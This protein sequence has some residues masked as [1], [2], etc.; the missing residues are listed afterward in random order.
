[1]CRQSAGKEWIRRRVDIPQL[2]QVPETGLNGR[3]TILKEGQVTLNRE[4]IFFL[5]NIVLPL[6]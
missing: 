1:M 5:I 6:A 3:N 4:L 2:F